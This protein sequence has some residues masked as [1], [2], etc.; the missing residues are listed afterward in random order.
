MKNLLPDHIIYY[1][2]KFIWMTISM[3]KGICL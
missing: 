1:D 3:Q 2:P